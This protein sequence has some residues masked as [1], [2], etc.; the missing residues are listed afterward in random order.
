MADAGTLSRE[1]PVI[2]IFQR[3]GGFARYRMPLGEMR[4]AAYQ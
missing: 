1:L 2:S 4:L 3:L